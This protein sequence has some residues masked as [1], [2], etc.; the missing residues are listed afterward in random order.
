M[1]EVVQIKDWR[2]SDGTTKAIREYPCEG[3]PDLSI[4][5]DEPIHVV[6]GLA[7]FVLRMYCALHQIG[8]EIRMWQYC[9]P[10]SHASCSD[11]FSMYL[12]YKLRF[13]TVKK[14]LEMNRS[15]CRNVQ[16]LLN[17]LVMESEGLL[18]FLPLS[19]VA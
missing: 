12:F 16:E 9:P 1:G 7:S 18:F 10:P 8:Q 17:I 19:P 6:C 4:S 11:S 13:L 14:E 15:Q 2:L 5:K 3:L